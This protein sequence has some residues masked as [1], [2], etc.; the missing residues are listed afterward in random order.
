MRCPWVLR[1]E[2][3]KGRTQLTAET[4]K[5]V[6]FRLTC[7]RLNLQAPKGSIEAQGAVKL[8][9]P[10][11]DG[12]CD[13]LTITWQN[14][15][16]VLEGKAQMKCHRNGQDL[17]LQSERLS[18]RLS[19]GRIDNSVEAEESDAPAARPSANAKRRR[20]AVED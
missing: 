3:V 1:V 5:D 16:V 9:S 12:T 6:Q 17:E 18:L 11:I 19:A 4:S 7:E 10:G 2:I 20:T 15:Q 14:D 13:R 8:S